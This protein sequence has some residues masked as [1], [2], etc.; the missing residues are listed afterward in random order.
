M[1]YKDFRLI[2]NLRANS[3]FALV[4]ARDF[5]CEIAVSG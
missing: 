3:V 5:P 2:L 1:T 4:A